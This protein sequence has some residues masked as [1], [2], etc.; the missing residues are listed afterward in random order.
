[1]SSI[2]APSPGPWYRDITRYQWFV[3]TVAT[4]G[5]LFDTMDQQFFNLARNPA[6]KQ[7]L[8]P[9]REAE[10]AWFGGLATSIFL[11]GWGIGGLFFG[12]MGDK[13][14]RAKTLVATILTYSICTGLSALSTGVWDFIGYRFLTGLGV[15]GA[16]AAGVTLVAEEMSDRARPYALAYFQAFSAVG[17]MIAAFTTMALGS[18]QLYEVIPP[19]LVPWRAMFMVGALP[20]FLAI[21]IM[22]KVKE[23]ER[24]V[25]MAEARR[26]ALAAGEPVKAGSIPDLFRGAIL[27]RNTL[28][29]LGLAFAGVVGV[30]GIGFFSFDLSRRVFAPKFEGWAE[31]KGITDPDAI[32][33]YVGSW[34]YLWTGVTSAIQ[35]LGAFFGIYAYAQLSPRIGRV[36]TFG[37]FLVLAMIM[38]AFTFLFLNELWHTF[39]LIPLMGFCQLA[40]FGGYSVYF[41]EL[42][43][44]RLRSTGVSFCY[45]AGRIVS[46][47]GPFSLGFLASNVYASYGIGPDDPTPF[48]YAA[49]TVCMAFLVGL[50]VLPF[51]PETNGKPLPEDEFEDS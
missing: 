14:G 2:P 25:K 43:P 8:G 27:R 28:V 41:P 22:R 4:L 38:T 9:G 6:I 34:L 30:W 5:W 42:F 3:L 18:L 48:R 7:L 45:N 19:N 29:G 24:W 47:L 35:N 13:V 11:L 17:N 33:S 10:V 15:G 36:K 49:V 32:K 1:M 31:M 37:I 26:A 21:F 50:A 39:V 44:T 51:A 12:V 16:F 20:A 40:I 23:P 46:A